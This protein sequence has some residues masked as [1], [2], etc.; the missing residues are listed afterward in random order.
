MFTGTES[1]PL[2]AAQIIASR[3]AVSLHF[4]E[5]CVR[6]RAGRQGLAPLSTVAVQLAR[7]HIFEKR[8]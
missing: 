6:D 4:P 2:Q 3:I 5:K 7:R 1:R 8:N